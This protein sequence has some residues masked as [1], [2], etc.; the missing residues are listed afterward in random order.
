MPAKNS[1]RLKLPIVKDKVSGEPKGFGFVEMFSKAEGQAAIDG[2][3]GKELN[4]RELKVNEAHPRT[5]SF[6][7]SSG[8]FGGGKGG[9]GGGKGGF[10]GGRRGGGRGR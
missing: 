7:G 10:S 6:R 8:G 1:A 3:N 5:E 4:G 2:L 9:G